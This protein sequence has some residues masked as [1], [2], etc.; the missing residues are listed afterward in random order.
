MAKP[1]TVETPVTTPASDDTITLT[2]AQVAEMIADALRVRQEDEAGN[3]VAAPPGM[4]LASEI[5]TAIAL[6]MD[7]NNPKKV[8][9]GQYLKRGTANHP[10]GL[11]SPKFTRPYFQNGRLVPYAGVSDEVVT[12]LNSITHSGRYINRKVEVIVR[13]NGGDGQSVEFRYKNGSIDE[14]MDL[15]SEFRSFK[16]MV[17]LIA[18]EQQAEREEDEDNPKRV[19]TR[20]PFGS[21]KNTR[22]AEEAATAT[23]L[24]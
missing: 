16:E 4:A 22:A 19:V 1:K 10:L 23:G 5:G 12:L 21:G 14:R 8:T 13:E 17:A 11:A 7:K 2:R 6:A 3:I 18:A 24:V 9:Y 15:K 20:R